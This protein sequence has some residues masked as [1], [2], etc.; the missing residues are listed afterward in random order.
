MQGRPAFSEEGLW[1]EQPRTVLGFGI[2][3]LAV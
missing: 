3:G 2:E 1:Q